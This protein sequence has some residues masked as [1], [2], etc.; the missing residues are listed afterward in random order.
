VSPLQ[1]FFSTMSFFWGANVSAA[2]PAEW[3]QSMEYFTL[4]VKQATFGEK[5]DDKS[6]HLV[7]CEVDGLK[8]I[9]CSLIPGSCENV[10]LNLRFTEEVKFSVLGGKNPVYLI[11]SQQPLDD[12]DDDDLM[13][14]DMSEDELSEDSE[15]DQV[16]MNTM[17]NS[18]SKHQLALPERS[19]KRAR[20]AAG[21]DDS[22]DSNDSDDM[23]EDGSKAQEFAHILASNFM[24]VDEGDSD[25]ESWDEGQS[26]LEELP[27]DS[28]SDD[29]ED[30]SSDEK[31]PAYLNVSTS[32]GVGHK[33]LALPAI[34]KATSLLETPRKASSLT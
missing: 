8:F 13:M 12:D 24:N 14:D 9:L 34:A 16:K 7:Q 10:N 21:S 30:G 25:S 18:V 22:E 1:A 17:L 33:A 27:S 4:K 23:A 2:K 19:N 3:D 6:R 29:L 28:S 32:K 5:I 20:M 26:R 15:D 11:G 31:A